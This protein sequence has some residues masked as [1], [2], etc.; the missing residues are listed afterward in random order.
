[1]TFRDEACKHLSDYR[2]SRLAIDEEGVYFH[3]GREHLKGHILPSGSERRNLLEPYGASFFLS[4]HGTAKLHRYFHHLN[5][6]QGLC[7]NLFFP[8]LAE[9]Q[10]ELLTKSLASTIHSPV[11]P[12]FEALS[13]LEVALRR[14]SFDFHLQ[15]AE[16]REVFVEVKY[17]E[18]GFGGAK[19][20]AEHQEKFTDTYAP[21]LKDNVYLTEQCRDPTFFLKNYQILRNLV[22]ITPKSEVRFLFP[23][24]NKKV[25]RQAEYAI[26]NLLTESGRSRFRII[27][28]ED[29]V[30]QLIEACQGQKLDGYYQSLRQKYLEFGDPD[31]V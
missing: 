31:P 17:T 24:A 27:Y 29:L 23:R 12:T 28:L 1:M 25:K 9:Q 14:T 5:S 11:V 16:G 20:D 7:F 6:S 2:K 21:L 4:E 8:L 15:N 10:W 26:A 13:T 18:D 30:T 3:R 22:H 19:N